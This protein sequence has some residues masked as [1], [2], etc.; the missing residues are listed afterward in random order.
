M[1]KSGSETEPTYNLNVNKVD[2]NA[3]QTDK[4]IVD[5]SN[6]MKK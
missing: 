1:K 2:N 4:Y 5:T 3:F 6:N